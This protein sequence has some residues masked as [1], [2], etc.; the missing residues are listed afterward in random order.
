MEWSGYAAWE[1]QQLRDGEH[2]EKPAGLE[3]QKIKDDVMRETANRRSCPV[4][5]VLEKT[6]EM[7]LD[8]CQERRLKDALH[9][10]AHGSARNRRELSTGQTVKS[11]TEL[12]GLKSREASPRPTG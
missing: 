4:T 3:L 1:W 8:A 7:T 12:N 9:G 6:A 5:E 11:K 2:R 10:N